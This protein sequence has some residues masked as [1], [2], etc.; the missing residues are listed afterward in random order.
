MHYLLVPDPW[1]V[2]KLHPIFKVQTKTITQLPVY[3]PRREVSPKFNHRKV[4]IFEQLPKQKQIK[5][6]VG[7]LKLNPSSK[8]KQLLFTQAEIKTNFK[9][10]NFE[11]LFYAVNNL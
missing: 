11:T 4:Q 10:T 1:T 2:D 7:G 9:L 8:F 6:K 3:Y 5:L